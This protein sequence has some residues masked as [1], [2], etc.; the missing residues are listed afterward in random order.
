VTKQAR[1]ISNQTKASIFDNKPLSASQKRSRAEAHSD[2]II[3]GLEFIGV[4]FSG[5]NISA[6]RKVADYIEKLL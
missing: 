3:A 4:N 2:S 6:K 1:E 5:Y